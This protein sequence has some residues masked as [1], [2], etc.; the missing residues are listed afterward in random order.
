[1]LKSIGIEARFITCM[2]ED[3]NDTDCHLVNQ[4]WLPELIKWAIIDSDSGGN[5]TS[6]EEGLPLSL[7]EL[8]EKYINGTEIYYHPEFKEPSNEKGYY[9]AYMAKNLFWF[10]C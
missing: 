2:P 6:N 5:W 10:A 4:V 9:Y 8:R 1:M 3:K 7:S